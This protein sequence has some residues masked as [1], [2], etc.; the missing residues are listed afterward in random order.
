[1]VIWGF[2][3]MGVWGKVDYLFFFFILVASERNVKIPIYSL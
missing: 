2:A 3:F 1:M